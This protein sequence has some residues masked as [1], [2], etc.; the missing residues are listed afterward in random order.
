MKNLFHSPLY[1]SLYQLIYFTITNV[2]QSLSKD[3]LKDIHMLKVILDWPSYKFLSAF[4]KESGC[5][6]SLRYNWPLYC[7]PC[8]L[9]QT[10]FS[11]LRKSVSLPPFAAALEIRAPSAKLK[12]F[13]KPSS[14]QRYK[15]PK[16]INYNRM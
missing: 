5:L 8:M 11:L 6:K 15:K 12:N 3:F 1:Q 10:S 7:F 13:V 2:L 16:I 9:M 14:T 4:A